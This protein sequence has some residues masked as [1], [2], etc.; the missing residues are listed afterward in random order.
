MQFK[1]C[2]GMSMTLSRLAPNQMVTHVH[3]RITPVS[4]SCSPAP[5]ASQ[6]ALL[7]S[8]SRTWMRDSDVWRG[9]CLLYAGAAQAGITGPHVPYGWLRCTALLQCM[10]Y[11]TLQYMHST[12]T[13]QQ[14]WYSII[15]HSYLPVVVVL[16]AGVTMIVVLVCTKGV[17]LG[18][19][20][21]LVAEM[22]KSTM[23]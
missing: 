23:S 13:G 20:G 8:A 15:M 1:L 3:S 2:T 7:T 17:V 4:D 5:I 22:R 21:S 14:M 12:I 11:A 18:G 19:D 16:P 9:A 6:G 10:L